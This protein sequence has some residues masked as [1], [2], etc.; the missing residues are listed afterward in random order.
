MIGHFG[1]HRRGGKAFLPPRVSGWCL[2]TLNPVCLIFRYLPTSVLP[3]CTLLASISENHHSTL[4][5]P[6]F[7]AISDSAR[8]NYHTLYESH[9]IQDS[10]VVLPLVIARGSWILPTNHLRR[11][12]SASWIYQ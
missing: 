9:I 3:T 2:L 8:T 11:R 10:T 5:Y 1:F 12:L 7:S 6:T 4:Q